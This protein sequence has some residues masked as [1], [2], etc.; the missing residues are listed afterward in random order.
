[1]ER[2]FKGIW[3]PKEVWLSKDLTTIEKL[4]L[5]EI[6]S[7]DNKDGC[8]A[9][10]KYFAEFFG[11]S[12]GRCTQIIK[13]LESKM[14]VNITLIRE[15]K[16]VVKRLIRVVNKLNNPSKYSKQPYLENA[17]DNN[18]SI[19][20]TE[21]ETKFLS[22]FNERK[23]LKFGKSNFKVL[24]KTDKNNLK[25][26]LGYSFKDFKTAIDV[27]LENEWAKS[28]NNQTP[29]HIL[30]VENFNRYLSAGEKVK[31][32]EETDEERVKRL[33]NEAKAQ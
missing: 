27:M 12:K 7:L 5:V 4:F 11:I 18:T 22:H 33:T 17:Q 25:Q 6:D 8:F 9:S 20:N 15:G 32:Q 2:N 23:K 10:N 3:I 21:R 13:S 29:T 1:M 24:S 16:Q 31:T 14:F 30:R 26:L 19:S 28:T